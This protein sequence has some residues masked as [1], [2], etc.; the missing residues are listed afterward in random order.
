MVYNT[1]YNTILRGCVLTAVCVVRNLNYE[2]YKEEMD[3]MIKTII[4][5]IESVRS[6]VN[7]NGQF[8]KGVCYT[9]TLINVKYITRN[10]P[11]FDW[12]KDDKYQM[13]VNNYD[14]FDSMLDEIISSLP[15]LEYNYAI[16]MDLYVH[17]RK[18]KERKENTKR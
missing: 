8:E 9:S 6:A 16:L 15:K 5:Y 1:I 2:S 17:F 12:I 3:E 13:G 10:S 18:L 4:S 11:A 14:M 7:S